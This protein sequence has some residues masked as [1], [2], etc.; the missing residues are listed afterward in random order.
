MDTVITNILTNTD[1]RTNVEVESLL[2][3]QAELAAPW[4]DDQPS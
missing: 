1:A 4:A 2:I 3:G